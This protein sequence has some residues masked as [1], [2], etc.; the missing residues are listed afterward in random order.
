MTKRK[1]SIF[2]NILIIVLELLALFESSKNGRVLIEYY[3][4]DSNLLALISSIIYLLYVLRNEK[5]TK[6]PRILKYLSTTCL[7]ITFMVVLF[8]LIPMFNFNFKLLLFD[9]IMIFHHLLCPLL[10]IITF[11][12]YDDLGKFDKKD[13]EYPIAFT[14]LYAFILILLNLAGKIDGPYPFLR[15]YK[16][17]IISNIA[18]LILIILICYLLSKLLLNIK[19]QLQVHLKK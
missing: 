9:G 15:V 14:L 19:N 13:V 17:G 8:I 7:T 1:V 12:F 11:L 5:I 2:I 16:Q 18:W 3:T 4:I 6:F 10:A